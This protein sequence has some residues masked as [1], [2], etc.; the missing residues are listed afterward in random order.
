MADWGDVM[1]ARRQAG[2]ALD[3]LRSYGGRVEDGDRQ[4]SLGTLLAAEAICTELRALAMLLDQAIGEHGA[5][6]GRL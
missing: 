3:S 2:E 6:V 1:E 5:N 4:D